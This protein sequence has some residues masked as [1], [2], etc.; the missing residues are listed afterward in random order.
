MVGKVIRDYMEGGAKKLAVPGFGTFMRKKKEG[1]EGGHGEVIF[2]DLLRKDDGVLRQL[3]E[4]YGRYSEVEAMALVDRFIFET[5]NA[6]ERRGSASIEGFGTM[7]IDAKGSY[8]FD[9]APKAKPRQEKAVQ[10]KL[11]GDNSG[12]KTT[13]SI[14]PTVT[15]PSLRGAD[16]D[17]VRHCEER[18][19]EA[20]H[21]SD[22][23]LLRASSP[24]N[25]NAPK[26]RPTP[27]GFSPTKTTQ[28]SRRKKKTK[29]SRADI[30]MI[31]AVAAALI[32]IL[33]M[34]FGLST[35][36][37]MPFLNK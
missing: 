17:E 19:D 8:R 28:A 31:I 7:T 24:R 1:D 25:D 5:K 10:E 4:D 36:G 18:S 9:Y 16:G 26:K 35:T 15:P 34:V 23:G 33:A 3:V 30:F 29:P 11:F 13:P 6:V 27:K 32:A 37:N 2:V 14:V 21:L 22:S 12:A 20:I